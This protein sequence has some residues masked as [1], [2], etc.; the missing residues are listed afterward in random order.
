MKLLLLESET[1]ENKPQSPEYSFKIQKKKKPKEE[2]LFL[3]NK[4]TFGKKSVHD[5]NT[6]FNRN[7]IALGKLTF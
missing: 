5:A 3:G 1:C 6:I 2:A 7:L 4:V